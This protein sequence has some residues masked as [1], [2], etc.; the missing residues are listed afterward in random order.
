M[1]ELSLAVTGFMA[2]VAAFLLAPA[3]LAPPAF[4]QSTTPEPKLLD[5]FND[6]EAYAY[7][8]ANGRVC[9]MLSK[10]TQLRPSDRNHGDVYFFITSRPSEGVRNEASVLV[11]YSFMENSTVTVDV[12][13]QKFQMFVDGDGAWVEDPAQ[14]AALLA[15]MRAGRAMTVSGKS[16]RGTDTSYTFSLSGV[17]ASSNRIAEECSTS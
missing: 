5:Q 10:P 7:D 16:S 3:T 14:E 11:G 6:W 17:T 12:D 1:K 15:A 8:G 4:A 2:L 9:Y 13:G